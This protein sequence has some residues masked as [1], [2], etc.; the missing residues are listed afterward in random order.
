MIAGLIIGMF[1]GFM[2]GVLIMSMM[3]IGRLSDAE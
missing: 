3:A 1:A 2:L